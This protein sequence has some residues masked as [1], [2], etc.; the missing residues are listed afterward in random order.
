MVEDPQASLGP[1]P[2]RASSRALC[3]PPVLVGGRSA[4]AVGPGWTGVDCGGGASWVSIRPR[5][6][7][8]AALHRVDDVLM[9]PEQPAATGEPS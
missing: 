1:N 3:D 4:A 5:L 6:D 7:P 8:H 2:T 9:T